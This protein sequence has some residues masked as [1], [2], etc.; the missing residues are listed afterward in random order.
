MDHASANVVA[1]VSFPPTQ[2]ERT[3]A[4][5]AQALQLAGGF[6]GPLVI[7]LVKRD[8]KFVSFHALQALLLQVCYIIVWVGV[9]VVW[10]AVIFGT[11]LRQTGQPPSNQ[12]PMAL[13]VF[14]PLFWLAMMGMWVLMLILVIVYSIKAGHGEWAAY[15]IIGGWAW[16]ILK[17]ETS[18]REAI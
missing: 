18:N 13:F 9:M 3:M 11:I 5:L 15:P 4:V 16:R 12:P 8:S 10:F 2:D 6:I 17:I 7:L 14:F 1:T